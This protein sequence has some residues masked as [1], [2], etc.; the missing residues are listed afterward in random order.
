MCS[1][2]IEYIYFVKTLEGEFWE[3]GG[4]M[5]EVMDCFVMSVG[6]IDSSEEGSDSKDC[7]SDSELARP[8]SD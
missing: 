8:Q 5:V 3:K 4:L 7:S 1:G 6:W 2:R